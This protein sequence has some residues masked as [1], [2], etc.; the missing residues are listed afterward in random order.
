MSDKDKKPEEN[1]EKDDLKEVEDEGE[2]GNAMIHTEDLDEEST[3][4]HVY[5]TAVFN[6]DEEKMKHHLK[7]RFLA[8]NNKGEKIPDEEIDKRE[9]KSFDEEW[10]DLGVEE[11]EDND[12]EDLEDVGKKVEKND[13]GLFRYAFGV[14][15]LA[16]A[17][18]LCFIITLIKEYF[19]E[20]HFVT[21]DPE[22]V[23]I[24]ILAFITLAL[25]LWIE[26]S[27]GRKIFV[28]G[29]YHS[30][31]YRSGLKR[32]GSIF[33]GLLQCATSL[34]CL[35]C[36]SQLIVQ[37]ETVADCVMNFTSLVIITGKKFY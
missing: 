8:I 21:D 12:L 36:S 2:H 31:F 22:Q 26:L 37:S 33:A 20:E 9:D 23:T 11:K 10:N 1:D 27:N 24:R 35:F 6:N 14:M 18:Q 16:A 32:A 15:L 28:H 19:G 7:I 5:L 25:Y 30:Y 29:C 13:E 4:S 34:C 17:I 3:Y